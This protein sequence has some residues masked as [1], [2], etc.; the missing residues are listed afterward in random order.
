MLIH[1]WENK[2]PPTPSGSSGNIRAHVLM[3]EK[4]NDHTFREASTKLAEGVK[5]FF[6]FTCLDYC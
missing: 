4:L 2:V 1:C 6:K 3:P 5:T